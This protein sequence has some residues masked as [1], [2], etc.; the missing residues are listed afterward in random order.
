MMP[1][2]KIKNS[3]RGAGLERK[4]LIIISILPVESEC[5]GFS[6]SPW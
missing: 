3:R 1:L 5:Q 6:N 4:K 2:T